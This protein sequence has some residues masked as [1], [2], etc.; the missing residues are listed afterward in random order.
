MK[1]LEKI[2]S[3]SLVISFSILT[4]VT[5]VSASENNPDT[6]LISDESVSENESEVLEKKRI[7]L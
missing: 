6:I 2:V 5:P 4:I 3:I 7:V 1:I